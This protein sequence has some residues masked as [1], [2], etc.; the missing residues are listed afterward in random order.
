MSRRELSCHANVFPFTHPRRQIILIQVIMQNPEMTTLRKVIQRLDGA[1][2]PYMLTGSMALNFYGQPRATN[3]FDIVIEI[4]QS[5]VNQIVGLFQGEFYISASAVEEA[6]S[7]PG[8]FNMIDNETIF[9]VDMIV[10]KKDPYARVQFDRRLIKEFDGLKMYVIAP[11][12]LILAKLEWSKESLSEMQER[13]IKNLLR[14][15]KDTLDSAY[16][17]KWATQLGCLERFKEIYAST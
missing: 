1:G 14:L 13:D 6:V 9:K 7:R 8:L 12:D 3:D 10:K 5:N 17:E 11:E 15:L 2:I 16:L 4:Q